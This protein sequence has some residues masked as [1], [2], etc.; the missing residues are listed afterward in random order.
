MLLNIKF[1]LVGTIIR[2]LK[3]YKTVYNFYFGYCAIMNYLV[4]S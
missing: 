2:K 4:Y 3:Q 1:E